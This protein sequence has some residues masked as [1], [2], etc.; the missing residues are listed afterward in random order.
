MQS[1][2]LPEKDKKL[3]EDLY[4]HAKIESERFIGYPC[5]LN[6]DYTDLLPFLRL[7]LNNIGDPYTS[8]NYHINSHALER[9][10]VQFFA[11]LTGADEDY[12]G[13]VTNGGTEGNMY[14]LYLARE[15]YPQGIVYYSQDTH[16]SVNKILR[17][18]NAKSIM[19][20]SQDNGEMDYQDL[21]ETIH[22]KREY[23]PIILANIGTTMKGAVDQLEKILDLLKRK[24]VS[25]YYIHCDAALGGM[26]LPFMEG[27]PAFGFSA[28]A[29]SLSISGHKFV[30]SPIPCGITMAKRRHVDRIARSIE[31]VGT[32]DTTLSGSRNGITPIFLWYTI[33]CMGVEKFRKAVEHCVAM[34]DYAIAELRKS[35]WD[36]WRNPYST[37]VVFNRPSMGLINKWQ[38]AS[39]KDIA[40]MVI[41]PHVT[42]ERVDQF[43]KDL[44]KE[45]EKT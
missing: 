10:V 31:Y 38:L 36:A 25:T 28:G 22:I 35:G 9:E 16:Y 19:I 41:M 30:G 8:S 7:G 44:Q 21:E 29:D 45:R 4:Q 27:A 42:K 33:K 18:L 23:V 11:E 32:L 37:T 43:I 12:W 34:T 40:H 17:I 39:Y 26:I 5:N 3:L 6:F 15:L 14:G 13:Y 2:S 20:R 24:A 1:N